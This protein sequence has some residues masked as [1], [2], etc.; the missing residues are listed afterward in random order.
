MTAGAGTVHVGNVHVGWV[1]PAGHGHDFQ[2]A[3]DAPAKLTELARRTLRRLPPLKG[4]KRLAVTRPGFALT[5]A[6]EQ[7]R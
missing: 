7:A 4:A 2:A 6:F 1:V 5:V 3:P